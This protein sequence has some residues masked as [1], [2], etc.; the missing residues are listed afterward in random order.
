MTEST[1]ISLQDLR[2]VFDVLIQHIESTQGLT[3]ELEVDYFWSIPPS[4]LYQ[5]YKEPDEL[6]V[7]QLTESLDNLKVIIEDPT[8]AT[9][10]GLVWLSDVIRAVGHAI[11]R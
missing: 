6:T 10:Y 9:S 4:D 8:R 11:V 3:I 7:G 5:L 2:R 1:R